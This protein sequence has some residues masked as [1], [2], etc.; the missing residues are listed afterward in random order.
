MPNSAVKRSCADDAAN[1]ATAMCYEGLRYQKSPQLSCV[2]FPSFIKQ[3]N[4]QG[5]SAHESVIARR[6]IKRN[7]FIANRLTRTPPVNLCR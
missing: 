5:A 2:S 3:E 1:I 6:L 7:L 4:N